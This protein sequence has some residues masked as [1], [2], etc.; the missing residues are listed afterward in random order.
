MY[1]VTGTTCT[2]YIIHKIYIAAEDEWGCGLNPLSFRI[3]RYGNFTNCENV[4]TDLMDPNRPSESSNEDDKRDGNARPQVN[5]VEKLGT[6]QGMDIISR[7]PR[8][9]YTLRINRTSI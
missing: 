1:N 6:W 5:C 2:Q 4:C 7:R 9:F 8:G 3:M